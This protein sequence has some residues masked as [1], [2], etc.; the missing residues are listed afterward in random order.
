M[1][2]VYHADHTAG[3]RLTLGKLAVLGVV[4]LVF[5]IVATALVLVLNKGG[6]AAG[7]SLHVWFVRALWIAIALLSV[8]SLATLALSGIFWV[9]YQWRRAD[10]DAA[11]AEASGELKTR[12]AY[13]RSDDE[14]NS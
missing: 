9:V 14:P 3:I 10:L 2:R 6:E 5:V 8:I 12:L 7:S 4:G 13:L 1:R 11:G